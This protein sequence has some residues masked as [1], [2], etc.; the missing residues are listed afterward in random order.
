MR[1]QES[2]KIENEGPGKTQARSG[3]HRNIARI[4]AHNPEREERAGQPEYRQPNKPRSR[5]DCR[6]KGAA[7]ATNSCVY[8]GGK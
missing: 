5:A 6:G 7:E 8:G 1:F 3:L 2:G 4:S